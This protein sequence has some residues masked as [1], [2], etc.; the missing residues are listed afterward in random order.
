MTAPAYVPNVP[1]IQQPLTQPSK[2]E[3]TL[4]TGGQAKRRYHDTFF[5]THRHPRRFLQGRPWT[6]VRE[7]AAMPENREPDPFVGGD[8]MQGHYVQDEYGVNDRA[9]TL[10]SVWQAPWIPLKRYFKFVYSQKLIRIDYNEM[11]VHEKRGL[12]D[13]Y[14]GAAKMGAGMGVRVKPGEIPD[15]QITQLM[16]M[17][18][19]MVYIA[20]A[21]MANDPWLL[22]FIDEPNAKLAEILGFT[23]DGLPL[24]DYVS[25]YAQPAITPQQV[26]AT[27]QPD[28]MALVERLSAELAEL[29]ATKAKRVENGKKGAAKRAANRAVEASAA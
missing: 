7:L 16:G 26:L 28:L 22:G 9:A 29:K 3:A 21:A 11:F 19:R 2:P 6:G 13:Y 10:N 5:D 27:P 8:M 17:P 25:P 23:A 12:D 18:S 20:Q 4:I 14:K 24:P 1:L 15:W